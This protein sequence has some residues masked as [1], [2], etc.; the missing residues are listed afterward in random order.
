MHIGDLLRPVGPKPGESRDNDFEPSS[1]T[2]HRKG[3]GSC[4][5]TGTWQ[6]SVDGRAAHAASPDAVTPRLTRMARTRL[7]PEAAGSATCAASAT[8][9]LFGP[10]AQ[11]PAPRSQW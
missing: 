9:G 5:R 3:W 1:A 6:L 11:E 2:A 8:S 10:P 7:S 4:P